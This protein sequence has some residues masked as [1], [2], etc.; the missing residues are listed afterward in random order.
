MDKSREPL[1]PVSG[2]APGRVND[3]WD[4]SMLI[5]SIDEKILRFIEL[6]RVRRFGHTSELQ[7]QYY[8]ANFGWVAVAVEETS[9]SAVSMGNQF[10]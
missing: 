9:D 5:D 4:V 1:N 10:G 2:C 8:F 6:H 3:V 7:N